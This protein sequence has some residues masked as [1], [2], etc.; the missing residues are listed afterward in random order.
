MYCR[1]CG[2]QIDSEPCPFCG[3]EEPKQT[4]GLAIAGFILAFL[5][6]LA[7]L[8]SSIIA[9]VYADKRYHGNLKALAIAGIVISVV[10]M[11][12]YIIIVA[13]NIGFIV[14]LF[15]SMIA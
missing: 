1:Y 2:S 14:D 11:F 8:I 13:L 9:T 10:L 5:S 3:A 12:T 7:G 6:P 15:T 4:N